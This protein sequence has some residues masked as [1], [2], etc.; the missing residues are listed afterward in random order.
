[1]S[2]PSTHWSHHVRDVTAV[3]CDG[4]LAARARRREQRRAAQEETAVPANWRVRPPSDPASPEIVDASRPSWASAPPNPPTRAEPSATPR[5][6]IEPLILP[7]P[8]PPWGLPKPPSPD[9]SRPPAV[10]TDARTMPP[11][12][13]SAAPPVATTPSGAPAPAASA[14]PAA[15]AQDI[16]PADTRQL[17]LNFDPRRESQ[18]PPRPSAEELA[19]VGQIIGTVVNTLGEVVG[20]VVGDALADAVQRMAHLRAQDNENITRNFEAALERQD[21]RF[22]EALEW[23]AASFTAVLERHAELQ[24]QNFQTLLQEVFGQ[25]AAA[26]TTTESAEPKIAQAIEELQETLRIG[27]GDVRTSLDRHHRELMDIVRTEV[28]PVAKAALVHLTPPSSAAA[29]AAQPAQA[30]EAP[31]ADPKPVLARKPPSQSPRDGMSS[32][33][34]MH[35]HAALDPDD[36]G[37]MTGEVPQRGP[38]GHGSSKAQG[39]YTQQEAVP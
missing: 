37:E 11:A 24:Q 35:V 15:T 30:I 4:L 13:T 5:F 23:Q 19:Q 10:T 17:E 12:A 14:S 31:S 20:E 26:A 38:P 1:M 39:P 32:T 25:T 16:S 33:Q 8:V 7:D 36:D 18:A 28:R 2:E 27:F 29:S 9:H 3:L 22:R 34:H 6:T 21:V